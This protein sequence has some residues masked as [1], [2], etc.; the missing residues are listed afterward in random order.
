MQV[1]VSGFV[2]FPSVQI[3]SDKASRGLE[4]KALIR[5]KAAAAEQNSDFIPIP[6][7]LVLDVQGSMRHQRAAGA[8]PSRLDLLKMMQ[9]IRGEF[10]GDVR[11]DGVLVVVGSI[12]EMTI[13]DWICAQENQENLMAKGET[14]LRPVLER[15]IEVSGI[16]SLRAYTSYILGYI[17]YGYS[18]LFNN[19]YTLITRL[20]HYF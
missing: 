18:M 7:A 3:K 14:D 2:D 5:V 6:V 10:S 12:R 13:D 11:N 19:K 16:L 8:D 15:T 17:I 20:S 4:I 1:E 9:F